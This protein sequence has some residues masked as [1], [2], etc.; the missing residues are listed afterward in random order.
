M[1][2]ASAGGL[3]PPIEDYAIIGD[4]HGAA[5]VSREGSIDW[6]S[7]LRL[8]GDPVFFRL[9]DARSG[10][11]WEVR[12]RGT[13][14]TSREYLHGTN[15]LRTVFET[16]TG[17]LEVTDF[18]PVGRS[19]GAGVHDYVTLNAPGWL[20]RRLSCTSG[21]IEVETRFAPRRERFA[22]DPPELRAEPG[23][24]V[25]TDGPSL[26]CA[27]EIALD[28]RDGAL[29]RLRLAAGQTES[30]VLTR[31]EPLSDPRLQAERLFETTCAFWSEWCEYS[32]YRGPYAGM[33]QRSALALKLLTYAP[34]GALL[35][36]ATTSLP[37]EIGGMRNWDYRFCWIRDASFA[38]FSLSVLGYSGE[39]R[40]FSEFLTRRCLREGSVMRI[41]Y[42]VE[43][44][45]F[46]PERA[47]DHLAGFRDSRPVRVGNAA[48]EQHQ[49][50][51]FGEVL[52]WA[53]LR[54]AVG[55]RLGPD[56]EALVAGLADHVCRIWREPD[57]G[58]WEIRG[59]PRHFT[60]GKVM[61]WVTLDRAARLLGDRSP[62]SET[63]S[64]IL[65][66]L[67]TEGSVGDPPRLTQ[68]FGTP[69]ADAALLQVPLLGL[70][71]D[72]AL[73]ERTIRHIESELRDGDFVYRYRTEDGLAGGE[74]AFMMTS[75]WLVEAL[76]CIGRGD[77]AR[78]LFERLLEHAN[79]VGLYAEQ[80][81]TRTGAFL[82]NFPQAF[83]HL[84]VISSAQ[85]LHLF[86]RRGAAG[87]R[88]TNADR[89]RR[90]VGATEGARALAY[91]LLRNRKVRLRSSA[92]SVLRLR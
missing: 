55:G 41:M 43:G 62:W 83:T 15:V 81:D 76:L 67:E 58:L 17:R 91:A 52:D 56:G 68:A 20:V 80:I 21:N 82:G 16:A 73:V 59:P 46:L 34:T 90:L 40:R 72:G 44:E 85:L 53:E 31:V 28:G 70:P 9:L 42:G 38:L 64:A 79:D 61:A 33:V 3:Q 27:G 10:G 78:A 51:V 19:R 2:D 86:D 1:D 88:G 63:R 48:S 71:L 25:V 65:N 69:H 11:A 7:L 36:A 89:A 13:R 29:I 77:E 5:L 26:W 60:Q 57:Q 39:A 66:A 18:M 4:C 22:T 74:G 75:F 92:R 8:D 14:R 12:P 47:L 24:V 87:L 35:A 50:D 6:C 32:R 37:E 54:V 45:P 49:L 23:R 84:A 30:L